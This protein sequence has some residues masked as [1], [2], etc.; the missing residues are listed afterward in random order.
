MRGKPTYN[1]ALNLVREDVEPKLAAQVMLKPNFLSSENPLAS[2]HADAMRG[3]I[4][5]LLSTAR[6]PE[7]IVIAEGGNEKYSGEAF[8]NF[9]YDALVGEYSVPIR[10]GRSASGDA[11][12]RDHNSHG[13][14]RRG[15]RAD[16]ERGARMSLHYFGGCGQDPRRVRGYVGAEEHDYGDAAQRGSHQDARLSFARRA[17]VC[18]ARPRCST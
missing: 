14:W 15:D 3:A 16:A 2:T 17:R 5:F 18:P 1:Q 8:A 7:E 12:G 10:L 13:R 4:D 9:G 11:V 6:P